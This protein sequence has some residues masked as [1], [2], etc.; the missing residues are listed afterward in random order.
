MVLPLLVACGTAETPPADEPATA[1]PGLTEADVAGT[2]QGTAMIAGTDSVVAHW[3]QECANGTCRLTTQE[4]PDTVV[5]TYYIAADSV[6][7]STGAYTDPAAGGAM[8]T[9]HWV[10]RINGG[11]LNGTGMLKLADNPDSVVT[12]YAIAG[13]RT[14]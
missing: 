5:S 8:V 12:R 2:W 11:Q 13:T 6:V 3:T 1:M 9:D 7:G 10:I 14:P 4:A